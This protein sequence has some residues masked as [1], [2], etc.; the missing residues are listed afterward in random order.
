[1]PQRLSWL[2]ALFSV[3]ALVPIVFHGLPIL[4]R[5]PFS[6]GYSDV[7]VF[8]L[9]LAPDSAYANQPIEYPVIIVGFIRLMKIIGGSLPGYYLASAIGLAGVGAFATGILHRMVRQGGDDRRLRW[10]WI[11]APSMV[12]FLTYNWD[13]IAVCFVVLAFLMIR[14][15]RDI[16]A[17]V[18][19]ALGASTKLYPALY[20]LPL[21]QRQK[22][23]RRWLA[24]GGAFSLTAIVANAPF[25]IANFDAWSYFYR[26]NQLRP[27]NVDSIWGLAQ[28]LQPFL[29]TPMVNAASIFLFLG[30]LSACLWI[31]RKKNIFAQCF[32]L[33]LLF[34]L[35]NKVFSPQYLLWLLPFFV[36]LPFPSRPMIYGLEFAN[37]VMLGSI[38][39]VLLVA[40]TSAAYF[41]IAA[42]FVLIRHLFLGS[43]LWQT[44]G[45]RESIAPITVSEPKNRNAVA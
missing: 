22:G 28:Y 11:L 44:L 3:A 4:G 33:T 21:L 1:M 32:A 25:A 13:I 9:K 15:E 45:T 37:L 38:L 26:L 14:K 19:L 20:L 43:F 27:P 39:P 29:T 6:I 10:H 36:L 17:A 40:G 2:I 7:A 16:L 18:F 41:W 34:L 31:M 23:A 42:C 30:G 8:Y 35:T 12:V 5:L 24:V